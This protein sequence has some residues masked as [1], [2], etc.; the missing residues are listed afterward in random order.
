MNI[1]QI[2]DTHLSH[3]GGVTNENFKQIAQFINEQLRPD[4]VVH[5]GDLVILDP[6]NKEDRA[7]A[8]ELLEL[9][10][11]PLFVIPGNHDIGEPEEDAFGGIH[12]TSELLKDF[13]DSFGPDRWV[14]LVGDY[15]LVGFNSELLGAGIPEEQAQ[16]DWLASLPDQIGDRSTLVFSHKGLDESLAPDTPYNLSITGE[17]VDR[18]LQVFNQLSVKA[19]ISGHLHI[20]AETSIG[21]VPAISGPSTAFIAGAVKMP[22]L[23]QLGVV[24]YLC[25]NG[26]VKAYFR[27]IPT[28]T[29]GAPFAI[30]VFHEHLADMGIVLDDILN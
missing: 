3:R 1:V 9:I 15:A 18:L 12:T 8:K 21:G 13:T 7:T 5:S 28:L 22:G 29:E 19:Y 24:E 20:F 16:W 11:A 25:E 17:H 6:N 23:E 30:P 26:D 27:S 2:S 4:A 14:R 10:N